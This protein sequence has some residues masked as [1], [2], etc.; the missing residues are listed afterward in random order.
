MNAIIDAAVGH[1][2]TVLSILVLVLLAGISSY[3]NIPKEAKPDINIPII[4]VPMNHDGISPEDA[5]RLLVRPMEQELRS[6]EG[7]KDMKSTAREGSAYVLL[8][9]DA[10]FNADQALADVRAQ[11]DV[12]KKDLPDDTEEPIASEVNVGLFPVLVVTLAGDVPERTL[13][14]LA[15]NLQRELE[16][17]PGV[18]EADIAGDRE[19]ILEVLVDPLKMETYNIS[20]EELVTAVTSNNQ[21]I[22][23]GAMDTGKGRFS[24]K[25]PGLFESAKDVLELPIKV[26][27]DGIVT[28]RDIT[29]VRRGFKDAASFARIN[30]RPGV[31]LEIKKRLGENI[32]DTIEDVRN[33][34]LERQKD[35]PSNIEV[36]F[37]QDESTDI[38][39]MLSDLQN[40]VLSA[41]L[42][43]MI[44]V[45]GALGLRTAGLV[46]LAV[47]TSFLFGILVLDAMGFTVNI[48]VL[49][50]LILSVGMLVDGAIVVT[51]YADRKMSEG[52]HRTEAY[53]MAAKRM[54]WPITAS[55]ATTLAA[56]MPLVFWPGVVGEFMKFL[57]ITLIVT[58]S[59]SLLMALIFVPTLGGRIGKP[60]SADAKVMA[61]LAAAETGNVR[62]LPGLTGLY[63]RFLSR[64]IRYPI[65]VMIAALVV[66]VGVQSY[67]AML[68]RGVEFFPAVEPERSAIH[69]H[70]RGNLAAKEKDRL[71]REVEGEILQVRGIETVYARTGSPGQ[72][73]QTSADVIGVVMLEFA[74][75]D[76]RRTAAEI[77]DEVRARTAY[78]AGIKVEV[79]K[80]DV[81]P[82]T[83]KDIQIELSSRFPDRL[84]PAVTMVREKLESMSRLIDVEDERPLPGI[85][86]VVDVDRA[87]AGRFGANIITIGNVVQLVTNGIKVGDYRPD[88][89]NE[90]ID[91]RVRYPIQWRSLEQLDQLRLQ[92][93]NGMVPISNFVS[94]QPE[95]RTGTVKRVDG[96]RA[97]KLQANVAE[98]VLSDDVVKEIKAWLKSVEIDPEI[99]VRFRGADQEQKEAQ[100]FLVKAF[101]IALFVMAIILVTQFNSFYRAFLILTAVILSTVG[102]VGGLIITGQTFGIVMTGIGI[103][104]L[105][106]IVV[107]NNIVLI[108]TYARLQKS[109]MEP[110]EAIV[111]TGA[112]RLRPVMLTTVTTI[113]G[114]LPMT[115]QL[116][117]DF[118]TREISQGAPSTQWWVQLST[119]VAFGLTFATVL[120]LVVTPSMLALGARSSAWLERRRK[121]KPAT[122][123]TPQPA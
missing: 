33:L 22:A 42:L 78:L 74:Q 77:L 82:P 46:G 118:F 29:S 68:G 45:V 79:R 20:Q 96:L 15:N 106:G 18:L 90:E 40:N 113:F 12:V 60:G 101:A 66:L 54:A 120:T 75:W 43:V 13:I 117:I 41:I 121:P 57:P 17:L 67:Y 7:I 36:S 80:P 89:A 104:A 111:R 6:I 112:Q 19:E 24:I 83:G 25:V 119:A 9:F 39:R 58:L 48:V 3:I 76:Q 64:V 88:D 81:G 61:G 98:G 85:E 86:M 99:I 72:G 103:I 69:I 95:P 44:V 4:F 27:G 11:I 8:E 10:G 30:G 87:Q 94:R 109:G 93:A 71:V 49:F 59:G 32:I 70:A 14:K 38:R 122:N 51:E 52:I 50:A 116:N 92:T 1:S 31:T 28:L 26:Y 108:D 56:F 35:W 34:V 102:V 105:A 84:D 55:T 73:Q 37:I 110:M 21:L 2:R 97:I 115:L 91:I 123:P 23:A 63:A 47:P 100:Q 65:L 62:D 53:A 114:L 107:N 16:A 5:E